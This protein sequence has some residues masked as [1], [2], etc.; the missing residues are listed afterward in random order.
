M[1]E[2]LPTCVLQKRE[3]HGEPTCASSSAA[4]AGATPHLLSL[5][6]VCELKIFIFTI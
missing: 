3:P 4:T 6:R 2:A 5:A 1:S